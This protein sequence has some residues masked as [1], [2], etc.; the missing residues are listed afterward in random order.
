M[1]KKNTSK[2]GNWKDTKTRSKNTKNLKLGLTVLGFIFVLIIL[3]HTVNFVKTLISPWGIR[4]I[5]EKKYIWDGQFNINI[6]IQT[7]KTYL[8][9]FNPGEKK[10]TII[11]IPDE[12]YL[13]AGGGFG[14]WMLSSIF[15]LGESSQ[16]EM[17]HQLVKTATFSLFGVPID[18]YIRF[19]GES[20]TKDLQ[21]MIELIR[22]NPIF[23]IGLISDIRSDLTPLELWR[24]KFHLWQLR[25]DK[26]SFLNLSD[27]DIFDS[28]KLADGSTVLVSDPPSLD[29]VMDF[30]DPK[31]KQ[32]DVSIAVFNATNHPL[33]AQKAKRFITNIGGNVIIVS[34]YPQPVNHTQIL[35][36]DT[37]TLTFERLTQIFPSCQ[38]EKCDIMSAT[39]IRANEQVSSRAQI[40][41]FLGEDSAKLW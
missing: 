27:L 18:G 15:D 22:Q 31:I 32:E 40:N 2:K 10:A 6:V 12:T 36:E 38:G 4:P 28:V 35:A 16:N 1:P 23:G 39:E 19:K 24:L 14:K 13:D 34:N 33:L 41:I 21:N 11:T 26:V 30:I 20:Q 17:G 29:S 8:L 7:D 9:N 37:D 5:I 25:F 3:G